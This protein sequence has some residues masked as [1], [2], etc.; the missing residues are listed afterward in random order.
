MNKV[1]V[2]TMQNNIGCLTRELVDKCNVVLIKRIFYSGLIVRR[3]MMLRSSSFPVF[4]SSHN[5][6]NKQYGHIYHG[7]SVLLRHKPVSF[8]Q[9]YTIVKMAKQ[10]KEFSAQHENDDVGQDYEYIFGN[11]SQQYFIIGMPI[12]IGTLLLSFGAVGKNVVDYKILGKPLE[13][14]EIITSYSDVNPL[15]ISYVG[16]SVLSLLAVAVIV[17]CKNFM[18]RMYYN[19]VTGQYIGIILR[20]GI[21]RKKIHFTQNDITELREYSIRGNLLVKGYQ[22]LISEKG[23]TSL[24]QYNQFMGYTPDRTSSVQPAKLLMENSK[25]EKANQFEQHYREKRKLKQAS[26]T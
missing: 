12:L 24:Q 23:F 2:S 20:Y 26:K 8:L 14:V 4:D 16:L 21:Y 15:H 19:K 9:K 11:H 3:G 13:K 22:V 25:N 6:F 18:I 7:G 10:A 17:L 1:F 5:S